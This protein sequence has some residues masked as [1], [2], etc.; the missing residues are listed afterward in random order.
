MQTPPELSID[1]LSSGDVS[2]NSSEDEM[3][4]DVS[5]VVVPPELE[6]DGIDS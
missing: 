2:P 4:D 3:M 5:S 1:D 6:D